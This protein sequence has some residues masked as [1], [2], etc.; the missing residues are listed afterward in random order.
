MVAQA[1]LVFTN[2]YKKTMHIRHFVSLV[3]P[4]KASARNPSLMWVEAEQAER[5]AKQRFW[6]EQTAEATR[7]KEAETVEAGA[8]T[9]E[10]E[11]GKGKEKEGNGEE[12]ER[13]EE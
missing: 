9:E 7:H 3:L 11:E 6:E 8:Q 4:C 13:M 1:K 10:V 5:I 2:I 12:D